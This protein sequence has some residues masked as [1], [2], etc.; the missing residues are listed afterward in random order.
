M[1]SCDWG[2][3]TTEFL[4]Q[5]AFFLRARLVI[6]STPAKILLKFL[7]MAHL[8]NDTIHLLPYR[9]PSLKNGLNVLS[10]QLLRVRPQFDE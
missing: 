10:N 2:Q 4:V 7:F 8:V 6:H 1:G 9:C 5:H 3:S